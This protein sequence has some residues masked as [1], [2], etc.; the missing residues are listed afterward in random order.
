MRTFLG[1][2]KEKEKK[3]KHASK[4]KSRTSVGIHMRSIGI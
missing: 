1:A 4:P 2:K 3:L